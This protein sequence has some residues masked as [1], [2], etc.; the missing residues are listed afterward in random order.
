M[1]MAN[2]PW[3]GPDYA[4]GRAKDLD[5]RIYTAPR[6]NTS[7]RKSRSRERNVAGTRAPSGGVQL[8]LNSVTAARIGL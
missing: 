4:R 6:N 7:V 8:Q 1:M 2:D 5:R 3:R